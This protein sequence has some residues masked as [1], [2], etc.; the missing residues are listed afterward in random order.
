MRL[1]EYK[2]NTNPDCDGLGVCA[3]KYLSVDIQE[4]VIFKTYKKHGYH[5][6]A[7]LYLKE[8]VK[9][10]GMKEQLIT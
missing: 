7:L 2:L 5:D 3:P 8:E 10:S 9:F 1:G 4:S 6:I